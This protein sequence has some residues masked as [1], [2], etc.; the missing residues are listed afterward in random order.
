MKKL[1]ITL[2]ILLSARFAFADSLLIEGFEYAN[3]D[4]EVPIGWICDDNSWLAGYLE[5]DHNRIAHSGNWYA[6][7]N[8]S[9]SWMFMPL[10][11][12][13][14]LKYR[15]SLWAISDGDYEIEIWA[16]HEAN[17]NSMTQL[18][19]SD[20]VNNHGYQR[21]SVYVDY[22]DSNFEYFGIHAVSTND[23]YILTIDDIYVEYVEKYDMQLDPV[24][25]ETNMIPG[26]QSEFNFKF[27]NAGYEPLNVYM[28][29]YTDYFSDIHLFA[30]EVEIPQHSSF[31]A[32]PN[33]IV[34]IRG[35]ATKLPDIE[36]GALTWIDIMFTLDCGCATAMFTF[37][38][39]TNIESTDEYYTY[40]SIYPNPSTGN[41]TIE[42][43]GIVTITNISGQE[44]L[45]REIFGKE[46]IMLDKGIYFIKLNNRLTQ[47]L[48]IE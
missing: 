6:Y 20:T 36:P 4:G 31:P 32:A 29:S 22:L 45:S 13:N 10:Y 26:E 24:N 25:I 28:T 34:D 5:K 8:G 44:V 43:D 9:E 48:I 18:L 37:W 23:D 2:L 19:L 40:L 12:S 21:I 33:E 27:I 17:I 39:S 1:F 30:N 42:G 15:Y 41:V 35:A 46:N 14:Q 47:K 3:H 16:G 38:S 11:M 7:T